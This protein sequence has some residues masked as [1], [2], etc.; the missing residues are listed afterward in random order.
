MC[1]DAVHNARTLL[2][3]LKT[4]ANV[5]ESEGKKAEDEVGRERR[6]RV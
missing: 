1:A 6:N 4:R 3:D 5:L 2:D